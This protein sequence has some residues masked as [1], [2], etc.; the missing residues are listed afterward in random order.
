MPCFICSYSLA[1]LYLEKGKIKLNILFLLLSLNIFCVITKPVFLPY[2]GII[3][4]WSLYKIKNLNHKFLYCFFGTFFSIICYIPLFIT[5]LKV[6]NDPFLIF[7]SINENNYQWFYEYRNF[8]SNI[9]MD[10]TDE[11]QNIFIRTVLIPIKL[12]VP[13]K[14]SDAEGV[15]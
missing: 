1:Y 9:R 10:Y 8:M 7:F 12:I 14:F 11:F 13:L 4:V 3:S 2:L 5:K 15:F 6:Y